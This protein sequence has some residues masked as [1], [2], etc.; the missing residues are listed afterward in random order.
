M[1]KKIFTFLIVIFPLLSIYQSGISTLTI[2]DIFLISLFPF[3]L[4][5]L[6]KTRKTIKISFVLLSITFL[7]CIQMM[8]FMILG[9]IDTSSIFTTLR[10]LLYYFT[11]AI[12]T[13]ELFLIIDGIK[14][15]KIISL[16]SSILYIVQFF[17]LK[18]GDFFLPGTIPFLKTEVDEYNLIMKNHLWTSSAYARPRSFFGEPSHFAVYVSLCLA[19]LLIREKKRNWK[20]I[21]I[22]TFAMLLSGSGM[23][24][25]LCAIIYFTILIKSILFGRLTLK[26]I[27]LVILCLSI[28]IPIFG[29]YTTTESFSIFYNRTFIEKD[30]TEGRFGNFKEAFSLD[31]DFDEILFGEG[32]YKISDIEGQKYITSIPRVYTYFGIIGFLIFI[33]MTIY[34]FIRKK[35]LNLIAW[36][37]LFIISFAS[38]ILF[39][40]LSFVFIPYIIKED[41]YE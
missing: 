7:I 18:V 14:Y 25:I 40:N 35:K 17:L 19:I 16:I 32:V 31:K 26:K 4:A 28:F 9:K 36:S 11:L 22:L 6:F 38:E 29:S 27:L 13:K 15:Y 21:G 12:F 34:L 23:A 37:M 30:S 39:H 5:K 20:L 33:N 8:I 3:F 10:L 1:I 41:N 2:A 24:I